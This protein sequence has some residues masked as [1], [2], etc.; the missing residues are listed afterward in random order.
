MMNWFRS[1]LLNFMSKYYHLFLDDERFPKDVKWIELP[2]VAWV[3]VRNYDQFV[4]TINR[5]GLP[6]TVSFDHDLADEHYQEYHIAHDTKILTRG[7]IRYEKM[8]EK[9]GFHCAQWMAQYC[10]D[11]NLPIP[12]YYCHTMN[13]I[14]KL[15]M[16]SVLESARKV[17]A[18]N[19]K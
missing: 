16:E 1:W 5:D 6:A 2:M 8:K 14:G 19:N 9:T 7:T 15:N 17:I 3:I 11:K 18:D 4:A 12:V 10:V 13:H